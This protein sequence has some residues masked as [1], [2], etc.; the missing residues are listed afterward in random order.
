V[1]LPS[2]LPQTS[3][4]TNRA[5][6]RPHSHRPPLSLCSLM[7]SVSGTTDWREWFRSLHE[8]LE[9]VTMQEGGCA[10][11]T[12][13]RNPFRD[14]MV[15][16]VTAA[17]T[18]EAAENSMLHVAHKKGHWFSDSK[19]SVSQVLGPEGAPA[20]ARGEREGSGVTVGKKQKMAVKADAEH[21][22]SE[23]DAW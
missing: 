8:R 16:E 4:L 2:L 20:L 3:N 13:H 10:G 5:Q 11:C 15:K 14:M 23:F 19:S 17:A 9:V 6:S 12:I 7:V 21:V 22:A 18:K 1:S